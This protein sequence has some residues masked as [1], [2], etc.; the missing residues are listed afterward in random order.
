MSSN[1]GDRWRVSSYSNGDGEC[2]EVARGLEAVG[3]RD[4]KH[5]GEGPELWMRPSS[6]AAFV[7]SV[8]RG[9]LEG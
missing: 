8:S 1:R 5:V 6:W 9:T 3:A 7:G 2:L 4:T